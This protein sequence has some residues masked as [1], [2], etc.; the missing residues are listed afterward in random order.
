[1]SET[2]TCTRCKR[3]LPKTNVYFFRRASTY[4]GF[5]QSCKECEGH[6]FLDKHVYN[7]QPFK[8][9]SNCGKE[10]PYTLEYFRKSKNNFS[11]IGSICNMCHNESGRKYRTENIDLIKLRYQEKCKENKE[12]IKLKQKEYAIKNKEHIKKRQKEYYLQNRERLIEKSKFY[13]E[14][15]PE[16]YANT[17]KRYYNENKNSEHTK[18]LKA[19]TKHKRRSREKNLVSSYSKQ[20]WVKCKSYF[21]NKCA[22]CG[23]ETTLQQDHFIALSKGGEYTINNIIP[24]CSN[25]NYSKRDKDF[26]EWYPKRESYSK[27]REKT[28][29]KYL[30][31]DTKTY[32]QQLTL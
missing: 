28:I 32:T 1:M 3:E 29:L 25:C 14:A 4:D 6:T 10:Y 23:K 5:H 30:N 26:F 11:G 2:K 12:V 18:I 31:Y 19:I 16:L 20:E 21:R 17:R 24:A 22:Y 8:N 7:P 9:C 15:K 27:E 13:R